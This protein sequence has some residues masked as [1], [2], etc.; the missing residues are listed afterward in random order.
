MTTWLILMF[1]QAIA[2]KQLS[3]TVNL[4]YLEFVAMSCPTETLE[5][6]LVG[7]W[8]LEGVVLRT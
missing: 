1:V 2:R 4:N 6:N 7:N 8:G 5:Q 3:S